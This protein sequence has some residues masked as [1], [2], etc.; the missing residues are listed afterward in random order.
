[1]IFYPLLITIGIVF[2][3][4]LVDLRQIPQTSLVLLGLLAVLTTFLQILHLIVKNP[5]FRSY[6][7]NF[8]L[9]Q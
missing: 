5:V 9:I 7:N 2:K 8:V 3:S 4:F 1:M 6:E